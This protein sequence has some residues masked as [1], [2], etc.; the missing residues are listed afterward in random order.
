M[1]A[2]L[3]HMGFRVNVCTDDLKL[4]WWQTFGQKTDLPSGNIQFSREFQMFKNAVKEAYKNRKEGSLL[5]V[6]QTFSLKDTY[7]VVTFTYKEEDDISI[8][9]K[10]SDNQTLVEVYF[11]DDMEV[12]NLDKMIMAWMTVKP[13]I[14]EG[15]NLAHEDAIKSFVE[16]AS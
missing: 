10:T 11:D 2:S 15:F 12:F 14:E 13:V 8:R 1:V 6:S 9:L 5:S 3:I 4:F 7:Y 16:A